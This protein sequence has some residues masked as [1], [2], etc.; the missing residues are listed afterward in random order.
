M[1]AKKVRG[2]LPHPNP[3]EES[4]KRAVLITRKIKD[5]PDVQVRALMSKL[6]CGKE[7]YEGNLMAY[8]IADEAWRYVTEQDIEPKF[9]FAHPDIFEACPQASLHYRGIS[10][11]SLKRVQYSVKNVKPWEEGKVVAPRR[12]DCEQL[13][14]FYNMIISTIVLAADGWTLEN[15]YRNIL[16]TMGIQQD[17]VLRNIIGS[18]GEAAVRNAIISWLKYS[19]KV[20]YKKS[21]KNQYLLGKN[22]DVRMT[23]SSEPDTRFEK[24]VRGEWTTVATIEVKS[25][26]DP[27]GALER[28]GA[29]KKSFASTP[30]NCKNFAVLGVVTQ[31]MIKMMQN[32]K[33]ENYYD[34]FDITQALPDTMSA[35]K[36]KEKFEECMRENTGIA[37]FFDDIFNHA[38]RLV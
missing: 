34:L 9:V 11:L 32:M 35:P 14:R 23:F 21:A 8:G 10:T 7:K 28:L 6:Q 3:S 20:Q 12:I 13:A 33:I 24:L 4:R 31:T 5:K 30:V 15:G 2:G 27:A 19:G 1:S 22:G 25:G 38:L 29:I 18:E 17:G 36:S 26:T 16:V 37:K